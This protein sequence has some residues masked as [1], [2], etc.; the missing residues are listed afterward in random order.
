MFNLDS[1]RPVSHQLDWTE[2]RLIQLTFGGV[3]VVFPEMIVMLDGACTGGP[4]LSG[5]TSHGRL[6][7]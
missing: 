2:D 6:E 4:E 5:S 7:L 1:I 3:W